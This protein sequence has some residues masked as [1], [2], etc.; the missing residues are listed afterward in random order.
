VDD[1]ENL[2]RNII[3]EHLLVEKS[4]RRRAKARKTFKPGNIT[5][6]LATRIKDPLDW[7][8]RVANAMSKTDGRVPDAAKLL[9]VSIRT[10]YR[11]LEDPEFTNVDRAPMGRP[12]EKED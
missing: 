2:I 9:G 3:R 11:T 10:L 4:R 1:T 7:R 5:D 6:L 12:P 8:N